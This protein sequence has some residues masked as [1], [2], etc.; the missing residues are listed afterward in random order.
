MEMRNECAV[1]IL[2]QIIRVADYMGLDKERGDRMFREALKKTLETGYEGMTPPFFSGKIY[3][4]VSGITG[5]NDPY[6][7]L[8]KEQ[9]HLIL[10][11]GPLFRGRIRESEDPLFTSLFYTLI[12]NI[13]DYGG[14]EIFDTDRVFGEISEHEIT[15]NDYPRFRQELGTAESLLIISDNAGEA[16]FDLFFMEQLKKSFP[17]LKIVY[18]VRSGP[19]INDVIREDAEYIGIGEY[20]EIVETGSTYAGTMIQYADPGFVKIYND[21]DIVISKGQGNFETLDTET[22][23]DI[24]FVFKVKCRIVAEYTALPLNSL[25]LAYG[26]S[27]LS[28]NG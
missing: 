2:N 4:A 12:G 17:G 24:F 13:I 22:G 19:A 5:N 7:K 11:N 20:A 23:K 27:F 15:V 18:G 16:V 25:V 8:R 28:E 10:D 14:V 9:N 26:S 1:C 3:E 21:A 6:K